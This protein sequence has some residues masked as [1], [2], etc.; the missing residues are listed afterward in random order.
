[1]GKSQN[2]AKYDREYRSSSKH[3]TMRRLSTLAHGGKIRIVKNG[4]RALYEQIIY[5]IGAHEAARKDLADNK[6]LHFLA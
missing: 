5:V 4:R 2:G 6:P 3:L 1:M